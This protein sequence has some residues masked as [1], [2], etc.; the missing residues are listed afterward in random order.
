MPT[1]FYEMEQVEI[2]LVYQYEVF[3]EVLMLELEL[4]NNCMCNFASPVDDANCMARWLAG[5]ELFH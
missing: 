3:A 4:K 5:S 2:L 1:E